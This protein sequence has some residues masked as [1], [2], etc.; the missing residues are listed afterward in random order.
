MDTCMC[1]AKSL[2]CSPEPVTTLLIGYTL[3]QKKKKLKEH[4]W[5]SLVDQW[6]GLCA[7]TTREQVWCLIGEL[8]SCMHAVWRGKLMS[9]WNA[10][11]WGSQLAWDAAKLLHARGLELLLLLEPLLV[12]IYL[13]LSFFGP[14]SC[15]YVLFRW[16]RRGL[17]ILFSHQV[18]GL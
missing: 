4:G 16:G 8:G 15:F 7:S 9:E 6:L 13:V 2:H 10:A 3:I 17:T 12:K 18:H 11:Q 5:T 14:Y 1:M